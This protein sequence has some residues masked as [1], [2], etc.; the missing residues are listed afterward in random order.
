M[1]IKQL[2]DFILEREA[3]RCRRAAGEAPPW[4][5]NPIL[6]TWSFTNVRRED[7]RVTRWVATNW[8]DD[9]RTAWTCGSR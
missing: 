1:K 5:N 7:D 4:T 6:S 8:R 3:I 2:F 9:S